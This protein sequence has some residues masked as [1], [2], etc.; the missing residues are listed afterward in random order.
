MTVN[1]VQRLRLLK[2]QIIAIAVKINSK[3]LDHS[4]ND[5]NLLSEI[6]NSINRAIKFH[7]KE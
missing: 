4:L 7:T 2:D 3:D 6:E 1:D 5:L